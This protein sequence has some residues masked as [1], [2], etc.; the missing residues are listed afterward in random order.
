[1]S[2]NGDS[3]S[4]FALKTALLI[5]PGTK[6]T[7]VATAQESRDGDERT[8]TQQQ[9]RAALE[10]QLGELFDESR[11]TVRV[12]FGA[13][14]QKQ[15]FNELDHFD[16]LIIG[17]SRGNIFT[18]A[19]IG[20]RAAIETGDFARELIT[21]SD[22]PV[23]IVRE[24]QGLLGSTFSMAVSRGGN[25]LPSVTSQERIAIYKEVRRAAWPR[26]DFYLMIALSSAIASMGLLLNSPAVIIGAMLIAPLM[27]AIIGTGLAMVQGNQRFLLSSAAASIKGSATALAVGI[28]IGLFNLKGTV[29]AEMLG[30]TG[31][32]LLDLAIAALS[33]AA[34]AYALCRKDVSASL[35]GVAIAVALVPP[36][37]TT[38]LFIGIGDFENAYGALLLF[39]T[40]LVA[41]AFS[42]GIIFT[43]VGFKPAAD[44][45]RNLDRILAF[46]RGFFIVGLLVLLVSTNLTVR[47]IDQSLDDNFDNKVE[48]VVASFLKSDIEREVV[49]LG[50]SVHNRDRE[51]ID[52]VVRASSSTDITQEEV[53]DLSEVLAQHTEHPL[54]VSVVNTALISALSGVKSE[55]STEE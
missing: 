52:V 43:M 6:I 36:L 17:S 30:R 25:L 32:S 33:G 24:Y 19:M 41:I 45:T 48:T 7:V 34:A 38:G 53:E 3:H 35:P 28:F 12:L 9:I 27:S 11:V 14:E 2:F 29:T 44:A 51:L 4:F 37:A 23:V 20:E 55:E 21:K 50:V 13:R 10:E 42:S 1:V 15:F 39:V 22:I 26:I 47:T 46:R 31:P 5:N 49:L 40:N 54:R 16:S 18:R 8:A